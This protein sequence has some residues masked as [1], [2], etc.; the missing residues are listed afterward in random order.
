MCEPSKRDGNTNREIRER[1]KPTTT[2]KDFNTPLSSM[3]QI[4]RKTI[5]K[6]IEVTRTTNQQCLI[7]IYTT[8]TSKSRIHIPFKHPQN[9]K[10]NRPISLAIK[11]TLKNVQKLNVVDMVQ[12]RRFST[13]DVVRQLSMTQLLGEKE[14]STED[15]SVLPLQFLVKLKIL[16][17]IQLKTGVDLK[18]TDQFHIQT[19]R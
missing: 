8:P 1:N 15:P 12:Q 17:N 10:Q 7:N 18:T 5:S 9:I 4:T 16:H 3:D 13:F 19:L 14:C 11:Q 6:D 2:I